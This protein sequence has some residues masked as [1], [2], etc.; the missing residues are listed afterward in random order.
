MRRPLPTLALLLA[1]ASLLTPGLAFAASSMPQMDFSDPLTISQ[2]VWM[3]VILVVLYLLLARWALP[4]MASVIE[5]RAV[6]IRADLEVAHKAKADADAA[7]AELE[8]AIKAARAEAQAA[9]AAAVDAAKAR[10]AADAAAL[11]ARLDAKL[12]AA[13]AQIDAA[14]ATALAALRPIATDTATLILGRL[15]HGLADA[16]AV[17]ARVSA[18][19]ATRKAA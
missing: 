3:A 8:A 7:A 2:V 1:S 13:E 9:I 15:A 10:A 19:L 12:E 14:R 16:G 5:D 6:R 11:A 17:E 18:V 4:G